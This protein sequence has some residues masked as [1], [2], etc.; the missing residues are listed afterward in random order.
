MTVHK[1]SVCTL[2]T[3]SWSGFNYFADGEILSQRYNQHILLLSVHKD[4]L[5]LS[6]TVRGSR[7][8]ARV[9]ARLLDNQWHDIHLQYE[10]GTLQLVVDKQSVVVGKFINI[11]IHHHLRRHF[12]VRQIAPN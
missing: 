3:P 7:V 10:Q 8:E 4:S 12:P 5:S 2:I 9:H 11:T 6:L 1:L